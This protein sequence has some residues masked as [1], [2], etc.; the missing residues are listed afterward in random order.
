MRF[1]AVVFVLL[2][3]AAHC[4]AATCHADGLLH[5]IDPPFTVYCQR[6]GRT[7]WAVTYNVHT[8]QVIVFNRPHR[9]FQYFPM[10][11]GHI[12]HGG[13]S[14]TRFQS[15]YELQTGLMEDEYWLPV[16]LNGSE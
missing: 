4:A 10:E 15:H 16:E 1:L 6:E 7:I 3:T 9:F 5:L 11:L 2:F 8:K 13:L 12:F 14:S